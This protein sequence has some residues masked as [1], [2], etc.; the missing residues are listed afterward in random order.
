MEAHRHLIAILRGI[1]PTEA[2]AVCQVLADAGITR[3]EIPL[4]S[5]RPLHSI[6][7][8]IE[9]L[10][11]RASVGAGTVLAPEEVDAVA[12]AGGTFIVSPDCNEAVIAQTVGCGLRSYPGIFSPTEAFRAIRAGAHALKIFPAEVVGAKGV[13]AM[14]AVLPPA[15]P[16]YAV[17]GANP[18]NFLE[19]VSAGCIG[20]GIGS[21]LYTPGAKLSDIKARADAIVAAYDRAC[22]QSPRIKV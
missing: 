4:N 17:G 21:Y 15:I 8:A 11:G 14:K 18:H 7:V 13:K 10:A 9:A 6:R 12:Q 20:F 5:P 19:F 3:I 1:T 2:A 22:T 16:L